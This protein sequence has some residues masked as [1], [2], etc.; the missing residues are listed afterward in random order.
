MGC[1]EAAKQGQRASWLSETET[2]PQ[3]LRFRGPRAICGILFSWREDTCPC[4]GR[5]AFL[6]STTQSRRPPRSC[7]CSYVFSKL[8]VKESQTRAITRTCCTMERRS[9]QPQPI[10]TPCFH[11]LPTN[12]AAHTYKFIIAP[13]F[14]WAMQPPGLNFSNSA[15]AAQVWKVVNQVR[16]QLTSGIQYHNL[17]PATS[18]FICPWLQMLIFS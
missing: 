1:R 16:E 11:P 3:S 13:L 9:L 4:C 5:F 15:P 12:L 2:E 14:Y 6:D 18:V 17:F 8:D 10:P 7:F